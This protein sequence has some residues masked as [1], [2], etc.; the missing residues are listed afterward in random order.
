[1]LTNSQTSTCDK[2][3]KGHILR[4]TA[5]FSFSAYLQIKP[6][7]VSLMNGVTNKI[8]IFGNKGALLTS[9]C[10]LESYVISL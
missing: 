3:K 7:L 6:S 10:R 4:S 8:S 2:H 9:V 5:H 1:M